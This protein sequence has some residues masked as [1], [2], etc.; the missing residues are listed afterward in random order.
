MDGNGEFQPFFECKDLVHHP[1]ETLPIL[2]RGWPSGSRQGLKPGNV[3]VGDSTMGHHHL[4][5]PFGSWGCIYR[6]LPFKCNTI[7]PMGGMRTLKFFVVAKNEFLQVL[8]GD[9]SKN[10]LFFV[11]VSRP[12]FKY[13]RQNGSNLGIFFQKSSETC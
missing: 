13:F 2:I 3:S 10:L 1:I 12:K 5:P 9:N 8:P 4:S 6:Q 11:F 7:N